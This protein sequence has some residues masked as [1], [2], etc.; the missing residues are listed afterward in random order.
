MN[1]GDVVSPPGS[2]SNQGPGLQGLLPGPSGHPLVKSQIWAKA[3]RVPDSQLEEH[4][5][6]PEQAPGGTSSL[7][8]EEYFTSPQE[9]GEMTP[10]CTLAGPCIQYG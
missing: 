4:C 6:W 10:Q 8:R 1:Q 3:L 7:L 9:P 2:R 5:S